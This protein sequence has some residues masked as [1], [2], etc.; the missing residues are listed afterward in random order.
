[1]DL[2]Q[3]RHFPDALALDLFFAFLGAH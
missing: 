2:D 1:M 3:P